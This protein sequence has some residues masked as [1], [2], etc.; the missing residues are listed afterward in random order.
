MKNYYYNIGDRMFEFDVNNDFPKIDAV[1]QGINIDYVYRIKEDGILHVKNY[2]DEITDYEVKK[3][4][5]VF[6]M[7][8]NTDSYRNKVVIIIRDKQFE[9]YF[10]VLD[11]T[12][13]KMN[14]SIGE[15]NTQCDCGKISM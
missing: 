4:N 8:S 5:I 9:D 14:Q 12:N 13:E 7:Y 15:C 2:K 1:K 11:E 6:L 3:N 10:T